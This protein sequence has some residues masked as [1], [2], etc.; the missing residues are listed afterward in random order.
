MNRVAVQTLSILP[1]AAY[2][3][4]LVLFSLARPL[5]TWDTVPYTAT[6]LEETSDSAAQLH[7][8]TY[9]Y[10]QSELSAEQFAPLVAG[11]YAQALYRDP[12]AF[13][14]Q[15]DMYRIKP[16]YV[17]ALR[18]LGALGIEPL[19]ALALLSLVPAIL[20]CVLLCHWLCRYRSLLEASLL[21]VLFALAARITDLSRVPVPDTLSALVVF[22][23]VYA[24]AYRGWL[25]VAALL[26]VA[27]VF[28]RTN[29]ILFSGLVLL[30]LGWASY[31]RRSDTETDSPRWTFFAAS[32]FASCAGYF[33]LNAAYDY[34]WWRLFFHT[35][36]ESQATITAFAEDFS[37]ATYSAV[38]R[39]A[40]GQLVAGGATL[41]TALPLFLLL[42]SVAA[43]DAWRTILREVAQ[44]GGF[45]SESSLPMATALCL[46]VIAAFFLLFPLVLGWDRFFLPF[47]ALITAF[48][49]SQLGQ[50]RR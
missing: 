16:A 15:L 9:S 21:V 13:A 7:Q 33:A 18:L 29:N 48:A 38:V 5:Y 3:L 49:A 25:R 27:S 22:A 34:Q 30:W 45:S 41:A 50:P 6:A 19:D 20:L 46:P 31:A 43:G 42:L 23:A 17:G 35:F 2:L 24:L 32:L 28:V 10:L 26:L 44:P 14:S 8:R 12:D 47:Y 39:S 1:L 37:F 4:F 11:S 40:L 36:V